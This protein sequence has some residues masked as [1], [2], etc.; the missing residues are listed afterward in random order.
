MGTTTTSWSRSERGDPIKK[1]KEY[2][3]RYS[4]IHPTTE[5]PKLSILAPSALALAQPGWNF[6]CGTFLNY[7][8]LSNCSTLS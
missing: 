2:I 5:E 4:K 6:F 1:V 7:S 8:R 3:P